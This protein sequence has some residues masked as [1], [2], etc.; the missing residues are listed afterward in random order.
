MAQLTRTDNTWEV[1]NEIY[2]GKNVTL[3]TTMQKLLQMCLRLP[4]GPAYNKIKAPSLGMRTARVSL[5]AFPPAKDNFF[6]SSPP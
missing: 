1:L 3:V 5:E 6:S 2:R 4:K